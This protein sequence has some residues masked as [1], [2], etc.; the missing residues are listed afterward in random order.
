VASFARSLQALNARVQ[1][2]GE[3]A[4]KSPGLSPAGASS[5]RPQLR[6]NHTEDPHR[7]LGVLLK[8]V[9]AL[10]RAAAL[11][12]FRPI[13]SCREAEAMLDLVH[14]ARMLPA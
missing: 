3:S 6:G 12:V 10:A 9:G 11:V 8:F 14:G 2:D 1:I 4:E 5:A 7:R 13:A